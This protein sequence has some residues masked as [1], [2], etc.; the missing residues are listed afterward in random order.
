MKPFYETGI[1]LHM[2]P[3]LSHADGVFK[4]K[5]ERVSLLGQ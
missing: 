5:K 1:S 4:Y 3:D 2:H